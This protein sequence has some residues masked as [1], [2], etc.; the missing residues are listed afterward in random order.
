MEKTNDGT[1]EDIQLKIFLTFSAEVFLFPSWQFDLIFPGW[2]LC[3]IPSYGLCSL[4]C[5]EKC[6][7]SQRIAKRVRIMVQIDSF[8]YHGSKGWVSLR[9]IESSNHLK[10]PVQPL[11]RCRNSNYSNSDW[12]LFEHKKG[13]THCFLWRK[14]FNY[15]KHLSYCPWSSHKMKQN[16]V[17]YSSYIFSLYLCYV[18]FY[19]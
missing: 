17:L 15:F 18:F 3:F 9:I 8:L 12:W 11:A 14:S 6:R 10:A 4:S 7:Q 16:I 1:I 13:G 5:T 19:L 2:W